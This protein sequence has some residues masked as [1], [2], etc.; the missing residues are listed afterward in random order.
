[1]HRIQNHAIFVYFESPWAK[2]LEF[3]SFFCIFAPSRIYKL[4]KKEAMFLD[5]IPTELILFT[6][7]YGG[8]GVASLIAS[9]YL[10]LRK[11]NAFAADVTPPVRLRYWAAA[12]FAVF[13]MGHIWWYLFYIFS[14]N[15][16]S[17]SFMLVSLLDC[18]GLLVT[19]PSTLF[20]MLQ[21]RKR[22]VWPIV[23]AAIPYAVLIGLNTISSDNHFLNIAIVFILMAYVGFTIYMGFAVRQ[24]GRWLRDN[25]ADLEHK[26]VWLS[27]VL[28]TVILMMI[29]IYGF[30]GSNMTIS[31]IVQFIALA[32]IGLLTWRVETLP[33]LEVIPVEQLEQQA[34]LPLPPPSSIE[35]LLAEHCVGTQLYLQHDLT[36]SQLA[37]AIGTNR[38]YLSQYFSSQGITYN[39]YINELRI[40]HFMN[41]YR[42]A[43]A[44]QKTITAQQL[45]KDSGYRSYSTFSLAFKQR[46]GQTVKDWM[47]EMENAS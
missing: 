24:Y 46:T 18:V 41:I 10:C 42:E 39:V 33:K 5:H 21:D 31:Y 6:M 45:A 9:I 8:V 3:R 19:I 44:A 37:L 38:T 36:S 32:F 25:Y 11:G 47:R 35:Q 30:D 34:Q 14:G 28:V 29:I 26:E 27:H 7:L 20:A 12:L 17:L 4:I 22:P 16:H 1:M 43:V 23:T 15:I 40:N 13:F 2:N